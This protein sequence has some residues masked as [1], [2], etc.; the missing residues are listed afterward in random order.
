M[1]KNKPGNYKRDQLAAWLLNL[2][3]K[4]ATPWYRQTFCEIMRDG[5]NRRPDLESI[6]VGK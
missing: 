4:V 5:I 1:S 3:L 6:S 2:V